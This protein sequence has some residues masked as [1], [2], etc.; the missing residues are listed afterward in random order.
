MNHFLPKAISLWY[1]LLTLTFHSFSQNSIIGDKFGGRLWYRP[2]N[3]SVG[4]YSAYSICGDSNQLYGWGDNATGQLGDGTYENRSA[5]SKT[6]GMTNIKFFTAGYFM[7]AIK[8][9]VQD[10]YGDLG[11]AKNQ[12]RY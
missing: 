2:Y 7:G 1:V 5:P 6:I 11:L 4:S 10:G 12:R 8:K 3:Y 9:T